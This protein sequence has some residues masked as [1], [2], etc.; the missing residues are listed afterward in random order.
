MPIASPLP[1][2]LPRISRYGSDRP[3]PLLKHNKQ[4]IFLTHTTSMRLK[5]HSYCALEC[6]LIGPNPFMSLSRLLALPRSNGPKPFNIIPR[7]PRPIR[8]PL[9]RPL[10]PRPLHRHTLYCSVNGWM[11]IKL[12]TKLSTDSGNNDHV[13]CLDL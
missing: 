2:F 5:S 9:P 1:C 12:G 13:T 11:Q 10:T 8:L 6:D 7:P 3:I 4:A